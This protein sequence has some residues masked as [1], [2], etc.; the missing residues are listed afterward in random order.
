MTASGPAKDGGRPHAGRAGGPE[1]VFVAPSGFRRVVL[2]VLVVALLG[3]VTGLVL[4]AAERSAWRVTILVISTLVVVSAWS[5]LLAR[6]PQRIT[7]TGPVIE[8]RRDGKTRRYDLEDPGVEIRVRDGEIAFAHYMEDWVVV[9]SRDV[10]WK[11]F[12][13][14]VMHYQ[15]NADRNAEARDQRFNK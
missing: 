5:M 11:T 9:R 13:D 1:H 10:E 7:V 2:G 6:V 4:V 8:I 3:V 15:N 14:V 12:S